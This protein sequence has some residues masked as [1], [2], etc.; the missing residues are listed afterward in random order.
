MAK[1]KALLAQVD[2]RCS[3]TITFTPILY[4]FMLFPSPTGHASHRHPA[5]PHAQPSPPVPPSFPSLLLSTPHIMILTRQEEAPKY[6]D[7]SI[8]GSFNVVYAFTI[9]VISLKHSLIPS[10]P[11][12]WSLPESVFGRTLAD[13]GYSSRQTMSFPV[14]QFFRSSPGSS[15]GSCAE[16]DGAIHGHQHP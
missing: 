11:Q 16:T 7:Y 14:E 4:E 9:H 5:R 3:Y 8:K 13:Q 2:V 6:E 1:L 10:P 15:R 12:I